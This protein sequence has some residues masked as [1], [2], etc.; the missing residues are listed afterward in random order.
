MGIVAPAFPV[1]EPFVGVNGD[2]WNVVHM[3]CGQRD[4]HD[5]I[6]SGSL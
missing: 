5:P 6:L 1:P 4:E 3:R 2:V